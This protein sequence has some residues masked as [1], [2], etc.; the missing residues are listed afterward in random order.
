MPNFPEK[1]KNI[2]W[3]DINEMSKDPGRYAG[4]PDTDFTRRR[5]LD[6]ENL[7]RLLVSMQCGATGHEL[8]KYFDYDSETITSSGF[9]QQ[10][11]KLLE[12]ALRHLLITFNSHFPFNVTD[13]K[14]RLIACDGSDFNIARNPNDQNTFLPP[15]GRSQ[16]GFNSL[17]VT[18]LYDLIDKRYLDCVIQGARHK[19]EFRAICELADRYE[20]KIGEIPVFIGDRG[21]ACYNFFAHAYEN[22]IN[23]LIRAKDI[24]VKRMLGIQELPDTFDTTVELI[25]TRTQSKKKRSR[26]DLD[27]H[28]RHISSN[29]AFDYIE[30]GSDAEYPLF[31]RVVRVEVADGVYENLITNIPANDVP[32]DTLKHWYNLRWGIETSFRD[33]KHTIGAVNFHAKKLEFIIQEILARM[34]LFNFCS[35][36]TL[37]VVINKKGKKHFHQV[38]FTMAMKICLHFIRLKD[39]EQAP[40]VA[41]LIAK[42]TLPIRPFR[43][44][45]RQHRFQPPSSFCY[46][47]A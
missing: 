14:Y 10:R 41:S 31:L 43:K 25:L 5:K 46:R 18:A 3:S 11:G 42:H 17:L 23:F 1:V 36:I 16:K 6:F 26:P 19:N 2:L 47:Y 40:D 4:N 21:F 29:V 39:S 15:T 27:M 32:A 44:Y 35:I 13:N 24:N 22:N 34:I 8:L 45:A 7:L 28:Y 33:L 20:H 12:N 30:R 37:H 38:N 9:V